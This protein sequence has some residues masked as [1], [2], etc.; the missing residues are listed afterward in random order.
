MTEPSVTGPRTGPRS[1]EEEGKI[2]GAP[3]EEAQKHWGGGKQGKSEGCVQLRVE[4]NGKAGEAQC[5]DTQGRK[6]HGQK[7]TRPSEGVWPREKR[8]GDARVSEV[9]T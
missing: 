7:K 3:M 2:L 8:K 6:G 5:H 9:K 4:D 1:K